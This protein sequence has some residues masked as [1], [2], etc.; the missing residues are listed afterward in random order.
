MKTITDTVLAHAHTRLTSRLL[1]AALVL[2]GSLLLIAASKIALPVPFSPVPVTGQTCAVLILGGLLGP[3]AGVAAVGLYLLQGLGGLPVFAGPGAGPLYF[4]G[5]TGGYLI[6]FLPAAFIAGAGMRRGWCK[7][8]FSCIGL[9]SIASCVI[10]AFGLLWLSAFIGFEKAFIT[11]ILPFL[12]G[13][14]VKIGLASAVLYGIK[15]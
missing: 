15:R 11:G 5:P 10:F 9:M 2:S 8:L 6:G 7:S 1:K 4:F 13:A 14:A 3:G 12:P